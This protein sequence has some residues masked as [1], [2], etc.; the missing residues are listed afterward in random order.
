MELFCKHTLVL[1][2]IT[3]HVLSAQDP[4]VVADTQNI[5]FELGEVQ[6]LGEKKHP[7][8]LILD[9]EEMA[10]HTTKDVASVL[11]SLAGI[12]FVHLGPKN[13]A[14]LNVRGFDLR[15]LPVYLDGVPVYVSYDGYV[16]LGRY[17]VSDLS[18]ISVSRGEA[19]LLL[20]PNALGGAINLVSRKPAAKLE[21]DAASSITLDRR[22]Y[23]GLI[24]ELNA[25][26]RKERF[27]FQAGIAFVDHKPFVL[28]QK[29]AQGIEHGQV[30]FNS[31]MRDMNSSVKLGYTPNQ[32][33]SYV[34]SY[35]FQDG[36]KG[37]PVY[38]GDDPAQMIRYWQFPAIKKQGLHFNSKT[39][40]SGESYLQTR[41]YY[42]DYFSDLRSYDDSTLLSQDKR[43]SFTSIYDDETV[44]GALIL[45]LAPAEKH[46]VKTA[47]HAIYDH[48]REHNTHPR[49]EPL[50][51]I[52]DMSYSIALEDQINLSERLT[53]TAGVSM[54]LKDN[55]QADNYDA[56]TD[57]VFPFPDHSDRAFNLLAGGRYKLKRSHKFHGHISRKN[58]FPTMRDRYSYRLGKSIPNPDL[59][60]ESS[61]NFDL[62]YTFDPGE[63][64]QLR[65]AVFYSYLNDAIQEVYGVDPDNSAIYQ[66]Q[67][68]GN[69]AYYGWEAE[70][71]W[72][73]VSAL[74]AAIQ[75]TLTRRENLSNPDLHFIDVPRH[76][77]LGQVHIKPFSNFEFR[78]D[79]TYNSPRTS[80]SSGM[81]GTEAFFKLDIKAS[82]TILSAL[83]FEASVSNLLDTAYSYREGYP[84]PGRQY[85]LGFRYQMHPRA[86]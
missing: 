61:W 84:A 27:Y 13:D 55:L 41:L 35:H 17:L 14:M 71:A 22:G 29:Y 19:S 20:G 18:R 69:A 40:F 53:F 52:R 49:V 77:L 65:S 48:H 32:S 85:R 2:A 60:S 3:V 76:K 47:I 8:S 83:S 81:Y 63:I 34:L 64:F 30:Q 50:R 38:D 74:E 5:V 70:L 37:V 79:G 67:N 9:R 31:G 42:H 54:H 25:G 46:R 4:L 75:Y 80:T 62:G 33:D 36:S 51:H 78:L 57:S 73:P 26:S 56:Q 58:R 12:N 66:S 44:G 86:Y 23:G 43:S 59:I 39:F 21:M 6:V 45:A 16:D 15:Q 11:S 72:R 24:S 7:L 28:S 1:L 10:Q 82:Y 68:A